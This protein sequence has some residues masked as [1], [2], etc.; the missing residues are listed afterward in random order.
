MNILT[1]I[2]KEEIKNEIDGLAQSM[3]HTLCVEFSSYFFLIKKKIK[4]IVLRIY[5]H[6]KNREKVL[7]RKWGYVT[8]NNP[9]LVVT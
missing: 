5:I 8:I 2:L 4:S 3:K 1:G 7:F 6:Q 9:I